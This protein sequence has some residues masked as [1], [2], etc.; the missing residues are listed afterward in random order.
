[1]AKQA[2]KKTP[3]APAE[4][5]QDQVNMARQGYSDKVFEALARSSGEKKSK[6]KRGKRKKS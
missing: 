6:S 4:M 5:T 3:S 2:E 1:M